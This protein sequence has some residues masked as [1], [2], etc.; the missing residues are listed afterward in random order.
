VRKMF[1][2]YVTNVQFLLQAALNR[3]TGA[4]LN[5]LKTREIQGNLRNSVT[6]YLE[7]IKELAT[8]EFQ[9]FFEYFSQSSFALASKVDEAAWQAITAVQDYNLAHD[10]E[11]RM[12]FYLQNL[13]L[14]QLDPVL[15]LLVLSHVKQRLERSVGLSGEETGPASEETT[16]SK[17]EF[18]RAK[19]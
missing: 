3:K 17:M 7:G 16:Q 14:H 11:S 19:L 13:E 10:F 12:V 8:K 5:Q 2:D 15:K 1:D 9:L 18:F 4:N 6:D